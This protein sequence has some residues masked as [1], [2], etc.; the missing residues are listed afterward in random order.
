MIRV[1]FNIPL[2]NRRITDNKRIKAA[3][4]TIK[5]VLSKKPK[6]IILMSHLG[7]PQGEVVEEL[8]LN[9]IAKELQ[10]LLKRKVKKLSTCTP[11]K[12][13]KDKIILL[14]NLR[15]IPEEKKNDAKFAKKLASYADVYINDAFG[16]SHRAHA[17]VEE[18]TRYLPS[19]AGLLLQKEIDIMGKALANPKRPFLAIMGGVKVSDKIEMINSLLKKVDALLIGGAMMFTFYKS[20]GIETGRSLVE[21]DKLKLAKKLLKK[22]KGKI[23]LPTDTLVASKIDKKART[24]NVPIYK[25][26]KNMLGV[27]IGKETIAI[28]AEIIAKA[29]T[30]IWNGPMGVFEI[31]K[32]AKG[33]NAITKALAKSSATTIIGGGDSAAAIE[34]LKLEKQLTHVSTGGGASLEFLEGKKL[35]AIAALERNYRKFR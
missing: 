7:R 28:Y 21:K 16:T 10:K 13:P 8:R 14:E 6:Q 17:S 9:P 27:D 31:P 3:L 2:K 11:L 12:M 25:I 5:Y 4:P 30:I 32:F 24:K 15:F 23:I 33:T 18:I 22:S 34:K 29:K 19:A 1:D 20:S 35:P 26:P